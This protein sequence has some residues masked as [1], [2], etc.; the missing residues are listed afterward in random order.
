[1]KMREGGPYAAYRRQVASEQIPHYETVLGKEELEQLRE[2]VEANWISEGA[3]TREFERRLAEWVGTTH[4]IAV[5]NCTGGIIVSL[6]AL[7]VGPGDEVIAPTF[8]HMGSVNPIRLVGATPV[9]VDIDPHTFTLDPSALET[10]ITPRTKA[11][12]VVH[13]YGHP[14]DLGR[15]LPIVQTHGLRLIEDT[16]QGLGVRYRG[17]PVG[18]FGDVGCFSFF[19][20]KA[21]TTGEGGCI[22]TSRD[23]LVAPLN[24]LK[25][26]G[27]LER[28]REVIGRI[29]YNLRFTDLQAAVGLAQLDRLPLILDGKRR[30]EALYR[31]HL[32]GITDLKFPYQNPQCMVVPHRVNILVDDPASLHRELAGQGI[33]CRRF[34]VPMHRQPSYEGRGG[35][36]HAEWAYARGL[37]LPSSPTLTES[38]IQEVCGRIRAYFRA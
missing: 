4:G 27:R 12:V 26:D 1:M 37:S 11:V 28:G 17:R 24:M 14:A 8:T 13:L 3:K 30:I 32:E 38:Q 9:L 19:A 5:S 7:G 22:L 20:D 25:H 31:R 15:I 16:A 23:D 21:I 33:G 18:S 2:V 35:Y 29:G 34:Y 10:A 36:P 6:L